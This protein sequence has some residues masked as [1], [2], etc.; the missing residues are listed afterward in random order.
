MA[1]RYSG[2][3]DT[4][5]SPQNAW[6][7]GFTYFASAMMCLMGIFHA[8]AGLSAIFDDSFYTVVNG[9]SLEI[10]ITTWGWLQLLGGILVILAGGFL[11]TGN[12][13]SRTVAIVMAIA[14]AIGA[15]WS[16]PYYPAWNLIILAISGLVIWAIAFHGKEFKEDA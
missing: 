12:I 14:S 9:Y 10:D 11:V 1:Y 6:A 3:Y 7:A 8:I 16:I 2:M 4:G 15:F 13:L 5:P